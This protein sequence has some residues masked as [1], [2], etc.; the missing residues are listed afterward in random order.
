MNQIQKENLELLLELHSVITGT[1]KTIDQIVN[2]RVIPPNVILFFGSERGG[3]ISYGRNIA[4]NDYYPLG[5]E[6]E[7]RQAA[8][9]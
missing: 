5:E 8:E 6:I 1:T 3:R 4:V 7:T 2:Q 9:A